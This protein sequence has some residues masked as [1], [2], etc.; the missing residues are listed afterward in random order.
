MDTLCATHDLLVFSHLRWDLVF[1][2]PQHLMS[3]FANHR[4]VFFIEEPVIENITEPYL[5]LKE[6]SP[7]LCVVIPHLPLKISNRERDDMSRGLLDEMIQGENIK[8]FS[9]WYY[10]P[11]ALNFSD[12][13]VG[14][15]TIYDCV[16]DL[17]NFSQTMA[18]KETALLRR[19]DLVFTGGNSVYEEKKQ[20][21]K[22]VHSFPSAIDTTHFSKAR[23]ALTDPEDQENLPRPR[24]GFVGG[25]DGRMNFSL[26]ENIAA[27]RP[28]WQFILLGQVAKTV[29]DI[30]PK[31]ENIHYLGMKRYADL[32]FYMSSWNCAMVP[33]AK[34][35]SIRFA[36]STK[37]SEYL[38]AGLPV[39]T[40]SIAETRIYH[41]KNLLAV[42]DDAEN[43]VKALDIVLAEK[44]SSQRIKSVD[45]FLKNASW[46]HTWERMS[47]LEIDA[48]TRKKGFSPLLAEG[49]QTSFNT[50]RGAK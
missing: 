46:D 33:L 42:A 24:I 13:L 16:D 29:Q 20:K 12:H 7:G 43:F 50:A 8:N 1:Q 2:R 4:R 17:V 34:H 22:R 31:K 5:S 21:H 30:L 45:E 41:G 44:P 26:L 38:A 14:Q 49:L 15:V 3:R 28:E 23:F 47:L 40:T 35:E 36:Y 39:V 32:P 11:M 48:L 37:I 9:I 10:T 18:E 27:L 25:I 19:A 6:E